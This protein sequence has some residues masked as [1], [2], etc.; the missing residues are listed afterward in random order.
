M[1]HDHSHEAPTSAGRLAL[2]VG[3]NFTIT[4]AELLGGILAGSLSLISDALHNASDGVAVIIAW[5]AMKLNAAPRT[6]RHTFGLKRAQLIA[7]IINAGA[8]VAISLWLFLE[9]WQRLQAPAPIAGGMMLAVAVIGLAA[10]T[11]GTLLLRAGAEKKP[12]RCGLSRKSTL[13]T[14]PSR[15]DWSS[16]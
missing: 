5:I 1:S 9:A 6:D 3:L 16:G 4:A 15:S 13:Y 7:A 2:V 11:L 14:S 10:N 8:L 12:R